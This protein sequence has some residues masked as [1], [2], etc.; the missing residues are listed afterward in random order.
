MVTIRMKEK[1][2]YCKSKKEDVVKSDYC[3][4]L[5]CN[6]C[7]R[8]KGHIKIP[9]TS[10]PLSKRKINRYNRMQA[11][12]R[13]PEFIKEYEILKQKEKEIEIIP[14]Q[15]SAL[16]K[17]LFIESTP[18]KFLL[19]I[20][21]GIELDYIYNRGKIKPGMIDFI[22]VVR[23]INKK[24]FTTVF[25]PSEP[26]NN[27]NPKLEGKRLYLEVD[28]R[29]SKEKL[30]K[31]FELIINKYKTLYKNN[32]PEKEKRD[33]PSLVDKKYGIWKVYDLHNYEKLNIY[34]ISK[35]LNLSYNAVYNNCIKAS[36]IVWQ[37]GEE[38]KA[39]WK[40]IST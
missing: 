39:N 23:K 15:C 27:N 6:T 37:V 9:P 33:K 19:S 24:P 2:V 26:V 34:E 7:Y 8:L 40:A 10:E 14:D 38:A 5:E 18:M 1:T 13:H 12:L 11:T 22:S 36:E 32:F 35:K 28:I 17:T 4:E 21:W 20:K 16:K 31:G 3:P 25:N 30:K 29:E